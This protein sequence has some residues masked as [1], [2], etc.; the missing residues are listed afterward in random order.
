MQTHQPNKQA[1]KQIICKF[2]IFM[3]FS[4]FLFYSVHFPIRVRSTVGSAR[5]GLVFP[6]DRI[7]IRIWLGIRWKSLSFRLSGCV[8]A[9]IAFTS[10]PPT[11]TLLFAR[12]MR[13][14][15]YIPFYYPF[16]HIYIN[17]CSILLIYSR[18]EYKHITT[19]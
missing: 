9:S 11:V 18:R 1:N 17:A 15:L 4:D 5:F 13:I 12:H 7:R 8:C 3:R 16:G 10:R 2:F 19:E 6:D 14:E